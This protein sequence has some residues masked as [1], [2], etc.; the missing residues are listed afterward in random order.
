MTTTVE[1]P[2]AAPPPPSGP[3]PASRVGTTLLRWWRSLTAMRTALVLLFLL[4]VASVPGSLLPQ[5]SLSQSQ[6]TRYFA[7]HPDLAPVL[8]RFYLFDV[9]SSP[10]FAAIYLLLFLSLIGCVVPRAVEH[11]RAVFA[12]PPPAPRHL[13][14]LPDHRSLDSGLDGTATLDVVEE[15]LRV[16]RF[17]VVRREGRYGPELS[18]EKGLLKETGNVV[19]HL[20]LLALLLGLAGGKLWGYEG[21]ILVTE[22]DRFC[23]TFQQ[24]DNYSSGALVDAGEMSPL[25]VTLDDFKAEYEENLTAASFTADIQYGLAGSASRGTTIGVNSPLRFDGDRVYVTGHGYAPVFSVTF[26]NG[27]SFTDISAPFLPAETQTMSSEGALK[28]PDVPGS[29][30]QLALQGLFAPTGS[31]QGGVLTSV[32][33]R[34]LDPQVAVFVYEGY[35]GLDSGLPQ[36]VYSLDQTQIDRGN[37]TRVG[38]ANLKVGEST[39]LADG[40]VITFSGVKQFAAMQVSHDPGQVWVL[41]SAIA[42]LVGLLGM[43]LLR[44]ERV[45]ARATA[46]PD[47][48]GTVLVVGALTRGSADTAPRFTALT[49]DVA[50]A[51]TRRARTEENPRT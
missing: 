27:D 26:P 20:A 47:G 19:F 21:S 18:A 17:R 48:A 34:P 15:E 29:D 36:N 9:F 13:H 23:N 12:A 4:A 46:G 5:R 28:L 49:D 35:L 39:T 7:D 38:E 14:R 16:R 30:E 22:G 1:R 51:L 45:F 10:W 37:L 40:T 24:Y 42:I 31:V 44:R 25:C 11:A 33:P 6:V 41:V 50:A 2:A 3:S 43:L 32:D 8:D